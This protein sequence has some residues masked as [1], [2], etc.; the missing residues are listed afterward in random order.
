MAFCAPEPFKFGFCEF[1]VI[2]LCVFKKVGF[3]DGYKGMSQRCH[4]TT[5]IVK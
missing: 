4:K 2:H 1:C 5:A 3:F